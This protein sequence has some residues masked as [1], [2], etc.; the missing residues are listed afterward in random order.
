MA[1]L[2]PEFEYDIFISYRQNDNKSATADRRD[3]W[4][5]NFVATLKDELEATLKNP[6]SIYFDENPHDGLHEHHEVDDSLR[7]KL[8]CLILIPIVSQTFCDPKSFAWEHEFK[9][10]VDQAGNDEFGLKTKLSGGNVA[11]RVLP[12]RIHDLDK[13][14]VALFEAE[15]GGTMRPIDFIYKETGVNRPLRQVDDRNQNQVKT[16]YRN[17]VNKVANAIKDILGSLTDE[18]S[19]S[20]NIAP[21]EGDDAKPT[22]DTSAQTK[23]VI[24]TKAPISRPKLPTIIASKKTLSKIFSTAGFIGLAGLIFW[25]GIKS[26]PA[27]PKANV[28]RYPV[29]IDSNL[30]RT[31][32]QAITLSHDGKFLCY[33]LGSQ[34]YLKATNSPDPG[35]LIAGTHGSRH[36]FFSPD[37]KWI[38]FE[39]VNLGIFKVPLHGGTI[40]KICDHEDGTQGLNW[41]ENEIIFAMS[42]GIYSVSPTGGSPIS[43]YSQIDSAFSLFFSPIWNPQLL[44]DKE[45]ILFNQY[46]ENDHWQTVVFNRK[47]ANNLSVIIDR[48]V[49]TRYLASNQLAYI[50]NQG[51]YIIDFD[52]ASSS[53]MG[54]AQQLASEPILNTGS[55][56]KVAQFTFSDNGILA[57]YAGSGIANV[58]QIVWIDHSGTIQ[59]ITKGEPKYYYSPKISSDGQHIITDGRDSGPAFESSQWLKF[60]SDQLGTTSGFVNHGDN[61]TPIWSPDNTSITYAVYEIG[62]T[63][64][65]EKPIDLSYPATLLFEFDKDIELGNWS[66]DGRYLVFEFNSGVSNKWDVAYFDRQDS[67]IYTLDFV[68]TSAFES[69]PMLSPDGKW[70]A[71]TTDESGDYQVYVVPFPGPGRGIRVSVESGIAPIWAPDMKALY[72]IGGGPNGSNM[73]KANIKTKPEFVSEEPIALFYGRYYRSYTGESFGRF[74]IHPDGDR[75]LMVK[76]A[77][78]FQNSQIQMVVNWQEELEDQ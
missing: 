15:I 13:K 8:K 40:Q 78:P 64:I 29:E 30:G 33:V 18:E 16:D 22:N 46:I 44:P 42:N 76:Y 55:Y 60:V 31:G 39:R 11:N 4:V 49:D 41:Y 66:N 1:S 6:V 75:F 43:I 26:Q 9:V 56:N 52:L 14:D 28:I 23:T 72:F 53:V 7:E 74:D 54:K 47:K 5:S 77:N 73:W 34:L 32:R 10:F 19:E 70:L 2:L 48:A 63:K 62:K 36:P 67:T 25:L 68:N 24:K 71:Y 3:G 20:E 12:V 35:V 65:F 58:R 50:I 69:Y 38:G 51:I 57:Y 61:Y 59:D 21:I 37:N 17:Q 45:T 27:Q